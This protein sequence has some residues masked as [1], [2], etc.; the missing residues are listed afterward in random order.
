MVQGRTSEAGAR[1]KRRGVCFVI[2][3]PS[4]AGKSTIANALRASEPQLR[5]SVSVTTRQPRPGEK[6]GVHYHFRT[7]EQF[8]EMAATGQLLEW[9]IVFGRGYGTPRAPVEEAL[10]AGQ[11]MVF[12]IDWQGHQQV[13]QALPDDVVSLFVLPPSLEELERRLTSR[14]SDHPD[15]IARRMAAARDEISHWHEFDHVVV[16]KDLDRAIFEARAILTAGRL[17]TRRQTGLE[18]FVGTFGA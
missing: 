8:E 1:L 9:A 4:G 13:R 7:M 18:E 5:H 16:N 6:E 15:E 17:K 11:D 10:A 12:D 2:S 14:A 3:A